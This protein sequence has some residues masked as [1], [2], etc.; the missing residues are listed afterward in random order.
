MRN[1]VDLVELADLVDILLV[2]TLVYTAVV[3]IRRTQ[4]GFV[5]IGLFVLAALYVVAEA[6]DLQLTTAIFR[7]VFAI[8]VVLIVVLFQEELRQLFERLGVWSVRRGRH[9]PLRSLPAD[10]LVE[11]C[12]DFAR[13]RIGALVVLPGTQPIARHVRGGLPLDGIVSVPLLKSVF[14]PHSPGHDGAVIMEGPRVT[15]FAAHLPLST[16]FSALGGVGTRHSA[17]LGLAELTDALCIVVSEERGVVSVARDGRLRALP[18]PAALSAEIARFLEDTHPKPDERRSF[19]RQ[20][21]REHWVEK[22][23]SL[24]F[25]SALWLAVVPGS[26]PL[27][28]TFSVPVQIV[29]LPPALVLDDVKPDTIE[30]TLSGLRREFYLFTPRFLRLTIDGK[31]AG[32]GRRTFQVLRRDLRYP[33]ALRLEGIDPD[34]VRIDVHPAPPP[35]APSGEPGSPEP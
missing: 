14:D 20:L 9:P 35:E 18:E 11:T 24:A 21:V 8:S 16:N 12:T 29:N 27:E 3:W 31:L 28:R 2:A 30:V 17:A 32:Q 33:E 4:A 34:E 22:I 13:Q 15:R 23:A 26:R 1:L 19:W 5:A 25:V 10:I 6:L 7:S